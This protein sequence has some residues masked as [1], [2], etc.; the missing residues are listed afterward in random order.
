MKTAFTLLISR[1]VVSSLKKKLT[2]AILN[3]FPLSPFNFVYYSYY[4]F[5]IVGRS[6]P[7]TS[8]PRHSI[9]IQGTIGITWF[10]NLSR[11]FVDQI[12][13][14]IRAFG[15]LLLLPAIFRQINYSGVL[16]LR[17]PSTSCF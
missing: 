2:K 13:R 8:M 5:C 1:E 9:I 10:Q 11:S 15:K 4:L 12:I 17:L 6:S 14:N 16:D 3:R 7:F